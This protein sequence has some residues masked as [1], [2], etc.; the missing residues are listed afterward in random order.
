ML[1]QLLKFIPETFGTYHEPFIGGGALFF[2]L[3]PRRAVLSDN[4]RR[5]VRT[6]L[7][8]RNNV[9]SV[10]R[11]LREYPNDKEF[12]LNMR[13]KNID[14]CADAAVAAWFIYL[15]KTC[16]N[17]LYRVNMGD[18]FNVPFGGYSKPGICDATNLRACSVALCAQQVLHAGFE[19]VLDRAV[20]G[21]LVY[22][23]PPY[24]P[25]S[26]TS[27]FTGYT[28][29]GF[30]LADHVRLRDVART[31]RSRGV[32]VLLSNSATPAIRD[33]YADGFEVTEVQS[34]RAINSKG[35]GRGKIAEFI[36]R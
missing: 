10:I 4:N 36:I 15:N 34:P 29:G 26:T 13:G 9:E 7:A 28:A 2:A 27:S 17:G 23:D 25:I 22:F 6:Y 8:I 3:R 5:L 12:F 21:D 33:L 19:T 30:A 24:L 35:S 31:L 32:H 16:F 11:T 14:P 20:R 18:R 1:P